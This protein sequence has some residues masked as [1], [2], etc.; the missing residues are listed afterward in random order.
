MFDHL[1]VGLLYNEMVIIACV[2]ELISIFHVLFLLFL[3][4]SYLF[5]PR[6]R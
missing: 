2:L 4:I 6:L 5:K 1:D 3:V